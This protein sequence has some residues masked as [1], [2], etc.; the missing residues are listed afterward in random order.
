M[1]RPIF[2]GRSNGETVL[3]QLG[4]RQMWVTA[5]WPAMQETKAIVSGG[6][7]SVVLFC[8]NPRG[9][10]SML[11]RKQATILVPP[12]TATNNR[13]SNLISHKDP[14]SAF[15]RCATIMKTSFLGMAF[16][17]RKVGEWIDMWIR[18]AGRSGGRKG[19]STTRVHLPYRAHILVFGRV[20]R[21]CH[22]W[23]CHIYKVRLSG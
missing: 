9:T 21:G 10:N 3:W 15:S 5:C 12:R 22:A 4:R 6:Y 14:R 11:E 20:G 2:V 8:R 17:F 7:C 16:H 19:H 13:D 23:G 18:A 1:K